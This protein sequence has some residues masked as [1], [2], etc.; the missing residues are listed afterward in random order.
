MKKI[1]FIILG[2]MLVSV[3][4]AV[5]IDSKTAINMAYEKNTSI[6]NAKKDL[7]NYDLQRKEAVKT[8]LPQISFSGVYSTMEDADTE[9]GSNSIDLEQT[10]YTGGA[11]LE[12]IKV[13][14]ITK[15]YGILQVEKTKKA[16]R[17]NV[18]EQYYSIIKLEE[19]L[20]TMENALK[21]LKENH[22]LV[23]EQY[24]LGLLTKTA[25]LQLNYR[26]IELESEII[27]L[28][29]NISI[30][31][32]Q[33]KKDIG[34]KE[35]EELKLIS[36]ELFVVS[37]SAINFEQE[38][39]YAKENN[40]DIK[41]LKILTK[42]QKSSEVIDRADLLPKVGFTFSYGNGQQGMY[43][44]S[45]SFDGDNMQWSAGIGVSMSLW[46]WGKNRDKYKRAKN[47]TQKVKNS[48]EDSIKNI[49]IGVYNNYLELVRLDKLIKSKEKALE[50]AKENYDLEKEKFKERLI[51]ATDFLDAENQLRDSKISLNNTKTDYYIAYEKYMDI[52]GK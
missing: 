18:L 43:E 46:D 30:L 4:N 6:K 42:L 49:E 40:V 14:K 11:V 52:L 33:L 29:N 7:E 13:A 8:G 24:E 1:V 28:E 38:L 36:E 10:I 41:M 47:E 34:L 22:N 39:A 19:N 32:L 9:Y 26:V 50:S 21:E 51:T 48:E 31:K 37:P 20:L 16:V 2:A 45:D 5:E 35:S 3:V 15:E 23:K 27:S 17:I 44:L 12:A 25:V